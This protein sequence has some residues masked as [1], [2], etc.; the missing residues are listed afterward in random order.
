MG[1]FLVMSGQKLLIWLLKTRLV[2]I[3]FVEVT[4]FVKLGLRLVIVGGGVR[5]IYFY[6]DNDAP[7]YLLTVFAKNERGNLSAAQVNGL[8]KAVGILRG[9][10]GR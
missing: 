7:V 4:A 6:Y 5:V 8:A 2:G 1:F 10:L 9:N 3:L